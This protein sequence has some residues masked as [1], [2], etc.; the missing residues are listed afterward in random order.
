MYIVHYG[1]K[2]EPGYE[3]EQSDDL[4][5]VRTYSRESIT[6]SIGSVATP[7]SAELQDGKL[8]A[9]Y[10]EA[11]VEVY[12]VSVGYGSRSLDERKMA[13]R[14]S[15]DVR[16][17][18]GVL[19]DPKSK[20]PIL[21]TE[22]LFLKFKDKIN[23]ADCEGTIRAA[24]L[25][26]KDRL[27]YATNAYFV[28]TP[29]GTGKRIFEIANQFLGREDVEYCHPELIRPVARKAIY[30]QQWHLKKTIINGTLIDA[31]ANVEA[32]H[33]ITQGEGI[34][35]AVIDDGVDID[36][37]EFNGTG[38]IFAPRD[39]T[40]RTSDPRPKFTS[41]DKDNHGTA[42]AGVACAN[43]THG[44]SGVAPQARLMPIR[45][46][47]GMGS[48]MEANAFVWAANNGADVIS[49][50][51][52]PPDGEWWNPNDPQHA[53]VAILPAST[54]LAIDYAI[55]NG[56]GGKGCVLLFAAGNGN[57]LVGNDGYASYEKVIAVAACNDRSRR[58]VY[59]DYGD[60]IWC[61]FPSNDFGFPGFNHSDPLTPGIWTTDRSGSRG[62]NPGY[63]GQGDVA[64]YYTNHFGGTSSSCPGAAGVVALVLAVNPLLKWYEVKEILKQACDKIDPQGG[65]YNLSGHSPKYG[66]GRL[67]ARTAVDLA[68]PKTVNGVTITRSF[69]APIR[70]LQTVSF[71]IEVTEITPVE[72]VTFAI[73][74]THTWVSDLIIKLLPPV[75]LGVFSIVLHNQE[76]G[77]GKKINKV[78]DNATTPELGKLSGKI[79]NGLW[80]LLIQDTATRDTGTLVSCSIGLVFSSGR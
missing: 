56:R 15:P 37:P 54:R 4:V 12:R 9:A 40:L 11:G 3:L 14:N 80:T 19:I 18:G 43:G 46:T 48:Q 70:D 34:T 17:A 71:S 76:G 45:L 75:N 66:Y 61:A 32:A 63:V 51:W 72:S 29:E 22:N 33:Q 69:N 30:Q 41:G 8:I 58:S 16:F 38:K 21:Y 26:I 64:G 24:G 1:S 2:D 65:N 53:A 67:N 74:L 60:A 23:P 62:Y 77:P 49:C 47:S 31:N 20:E 42:C 13:L 44:A 57:E 78:Y 52:G 10:P 59:S 55:T 36:H 79:C 5:V 39:V 35:I 68:K 27:S 7:L 6:R 73:D 25:T 28:G 50:S